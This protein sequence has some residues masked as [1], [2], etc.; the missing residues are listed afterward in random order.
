[1]SGI[2]QR[3]RAALAWRARQWHDRLLLARARR[4]RERL[5]DTVFIGVTGS[6]GKTTTKDI[7]VAVLSRH[8]P[9]RG[10]A[11]SL[12]YLIDLAQVVLGLRRSDRFAVVEIGISTPGSIDDKI[13]L[14]RPTIA[15]L[16]VVGRDH[17]KAFGSQEA[18]AEEKGKLILAL[19][20]DGTAVLNADDPLVR[21]VGQRARARKLWFGTAPDAD[22]RLVSAT[23]SY[24]EPLTLVVAYQGREHTC[25]TGLHGTHLTVPVMAALGLA[26]AA[27]MPIEKAAAALVETQT[28]PGRMQLVTGDDGVTWIRDDYKAPHWSFQASLDHLKAARAARKVAVIGTLSDYSLS[29][30]KLYPKVAK[31]AR[32][33]ADLVVFVG[34][35]ALR[36]LKARTGDDDR[37]IVG[38]TEIEDAHRFLQAELRAG[39]LVLMKGSNRADHL[40]RL[41]L[42]RTR[43]VTCWTFGCGL[44]RFCDACP[45]IDAPQPIAVVRGAAV[46]P[47]DEVSRADDAAS[48]PPAGAQAA[49][50]EVWLVV[51]LGN[52]GDRYRDTPHNIGFAALDRMVDEAGLS[53]SDE[54]EGSV[55]RATVA[56]QELWL[57]K[58]GSALNLCGPLVESLRRRRAVRPDRVIVLH[59]DTDLALGD[60]RLKHSGSDGG[61]KGLRSVFA[62]LANEGALMRV[63]IGVRRGADGGAA[64][65]SLV[66]AGF[67]P[68]DRQAVDSALDKAA[69][70]LRTAVGDSQPSRG[71]RAAS[72]AAGGSGRAHEPQ[73][74]DARSS[75]RQ[76]VP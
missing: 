43:P 76:P 13:A 72:D 4:H 21:A 57:L 14:A 53:W 33:A 56:G 17:I 55:A 35:H 24:P 31:Q 64:A 11:A 5:D 15:A 20:P 40:V 73:A 58:P 48:T 22:L 9:T 50:S 3:V 26:I 6:V 49:A 54:A 51:G 18:I 62:A 63:R 44:N 1:M 32:E 29:A 41:L 25:V 34:P 16:I 38:F 27:G 74:R 75:H 19:P 69:A 30:S 61:H 28:T 70:V 45:R 37:S 59:D 12:N 67:E 2:V 47:S 39:D 46:V 71:A 42:A 23:S 52:P 60:V 68:G 36:G 10:N 65:R 8:A 66:L 7:A